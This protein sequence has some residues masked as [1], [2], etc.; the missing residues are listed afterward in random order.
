[1]QNAQILNANL[2]Q[3]SAVRTV[4]AYDCVQLWHTIE[5]RTF[6]VIFSLIIL[7]VIIARMEGGDCEMHTSSVPLRTYVT[8]FVPLGHIWDVML[9]WR[10]GNIEKIL[11]LCYSIVYCHNDAQ[12]YQQFL[13]VGRLYQALILLGLALSF[14][15]LC[16]FGLYSAIMC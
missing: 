8:L 15:C 12:R 4:S 11:S 6:L 14:W 13:Q 9:V 1:M 16:V 5:H 3:Q 2:N 7:T 10:K